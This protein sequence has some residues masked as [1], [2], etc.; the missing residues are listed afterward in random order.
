MRKNTARHWLHAT[1]DLLPVILIPVFMIYSHRHD[2]ST[3][4]TV[5]QDVY[6]DFYQGVKNGKPLNNL[7]NIDVYNDNSEDFSFYL[8]DGLTL[9]VENADYFY[10]DYNTDLV[11]NNNDIIYM[12]INL[13]AENSIYINMFPV[14]GQA[15]VS[16]V[17]NGVT[18]S[19]QSA[20]IYSPYDTHSILE[21]DC[22]SSN[23]ITTITIK[24]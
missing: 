15:E 2:M 4:I 11:I 3:D 20:Y 5:T 10:V 13:W 17:P 12:S 14:D 7:D 24:L 21:F 23:Y 19:Y 1:L 16:D 22:D 9:E 8:D 18:F 6:K